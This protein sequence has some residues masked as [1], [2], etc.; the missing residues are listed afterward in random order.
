[1]EFVALITLHHKAVGDEGT[2]SFQFPIQDLLIVTVNKAVMVF[3]NRVSLCS[4]FI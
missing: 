4:L 2:N 3:M 1:M